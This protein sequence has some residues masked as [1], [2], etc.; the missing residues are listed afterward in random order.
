[1]IGGSPVQP[2]YYPGSYPVQPSYPA[3]QPSQQ[4][5][6]QAGQP[7]KNLSTQQS[8]QVRMQAAEESVAAPRRALPPLEVPSPDR[9]GL[10]ARNRIVEVDWTSVRNRLQAMS[11]TSFHLQKISGGYRFAV[12]VS[13]A[14]GERRKIE[15]DGESDAE[16]IELA[17]NRAERERR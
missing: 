10:G 11:V 17:L 9:L 16:A 7:R 13:T 12:V 4:L 3:Y 5:S 14:G 1:M 2:E 6:R 15:C 8:P